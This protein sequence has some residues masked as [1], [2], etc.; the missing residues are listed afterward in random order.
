MEGVMWEAPL[1]PAV[2]R[3]LKIRQCNFIAKYLGL[4]VARQNSKFC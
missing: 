2:Y 1:P 4:G 3:T